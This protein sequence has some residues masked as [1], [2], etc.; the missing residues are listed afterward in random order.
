MATVLPRSVPQP[1][2]ATAESRK[3]AQNNMIGLEWHGKEDVRVVSRPK[4]LI[5][6]PKDAIIAITLTTVCGSDLHMYHA[7]PGME[8]GDVLGHEFMGI[9]EDI[10]PEVTTLKRGDRVVVSAVISCGDCFY[11]RKEEYS[12]CDRS[13]PADQMDEIYGHRIAGIF[14]YSHLTGGFEGGQAEFARVPYADINCLKIPDDLKDEKVL[15]LSDIVCTGWHANELAQTGEGQSVVVWGAGPVGL[16][17]LAWAKYR[18]AKNLIIVDCIP[19]RLQLAHE[20]TGATALNFEVE[21]DLHKKI[22]QLMPGGPDAVIDAVGY[23][24]RS[25]LLHQVQQAINLETD[26]PSVINQAIMT[27]RKGGRIAVIGDYFG[28]ANN[29]QIGA[30]MEKGI[31]LTGSQVYVQ[32]YWKKLLKIIQSGG[33]DPTF[34][35]THRFPLSQ[36]AEAY[37][38]FD[39]KENQVIK[40][41]LV[42]D[43]LLQQQGSITASSPQTPTPA[44]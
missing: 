10:G 31:T 44:T 21:K 26:S 18:G 36:A 22:Q 30:F 11:C 33:I 16:L 1:V 15:F 19:E 23:R 34:V 24:A 8:K 2:I 14:G 29:F 39:K 4:P 42:P 13:N 27:C 9:V 38:Q 35:I 6:E 7:I 37:R 20:K 41:L 5:T 32:R 17:S 3:D 25:S 40:I 12:L 43:R 28:S